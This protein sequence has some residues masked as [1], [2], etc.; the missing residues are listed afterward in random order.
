METKLRYFKGPTCNESREEYSTGFIAS[1]HFYDRLSG[2]I[3]LEHTMPDYRSTNYTY[4]HA[5]LPFDLEIITWLRKWSSFEDFPVAFKRDI[6]LLIFTKIPD[7]IP[8]TSQQ[9][10]EGLL[11]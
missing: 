2:E 6:L 4:W 8:R 1:T 5:F 7:A 3:L 10:L 11:A 9:E